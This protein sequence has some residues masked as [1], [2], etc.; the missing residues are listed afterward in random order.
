MAEITL[1]DNIAIFAFDNG[2]GNT[3]TL[4][5]LRKLRETVKKVNETPEIKGLILTGAGK[6][7]SSGFDLPMFLGFKDHSEVVAFFEEEEEILLEL[8]TCD[9]PVISAINGHC[10][11][12]GVILAM[13]SDYRV[14]GNHPKIKLGMSEIKIGLPLSVC[15][16]RVFRFG[17]DSDRRFRDI[18]CFGEFYDPTRAVEMG[19]ADEVVEIA[20]VMPRAKELVKSW[21]DTPGRPFIPIKRMQRSEVALSIRRG[22]KEENWR[23]NLR[24]FFEK[25]VRNALFAVLE[26]MKL[27]AK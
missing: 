17:I 11:A 20:E 5:V 10:V 26:M 8:F 24:C 27:Q 4:D 21:I 22:I 12:A 7:F 15:Q 1:E 6:L 2:F 3:I 18:M 13:A 23:E 16:S 9:K 14:V 19:L 25:D